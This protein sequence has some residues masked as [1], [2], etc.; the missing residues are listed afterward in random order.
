MSGTI[1]RY[2]FFFVVLQMCLELDDAWPLLIPSLLDL[3][4]IIIII[5]IVIEIH[6]YIFFIS[7]Q[8]N[9]SADL[10][11]TGMH[12]FFAHGDFNHKKTKKKDSLTFLLFVSFSFL[13]FYYVRIFMQTKITFDTFS[14]ISFC[15]SL[16][17]YF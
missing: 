14:F 16:P 4:L 17:M 9:V 7:F 2:K 6:N 12:F 11:W 5:I 3:M 8:T 10:L 13:Y 15:I 1:A